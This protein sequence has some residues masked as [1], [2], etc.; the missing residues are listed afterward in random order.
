MYAYRNVF[1]AFLQFAK[2]MSLM[3]PYI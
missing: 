1:G 2:C 3:L